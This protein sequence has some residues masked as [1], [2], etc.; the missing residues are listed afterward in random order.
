MLYPCV[1]LEEQYIKCKY[2]NQSM[3]IILVDKLKI[4]TQLCIKILSSSLNRKKCNLVTV[5][6]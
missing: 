5:Q 4:N 3:C 1:T 6:I 2:S